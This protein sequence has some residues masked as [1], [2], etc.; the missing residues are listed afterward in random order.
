MLSA[1]KPSRGRIDSPR[2]NN[3]PAAP[4]ASQ[5]LILFARNACILRT[6]WTTATLPQRMEVD[7]ALMTTGSKSDPQFCLT[8]NIFSRE[9]IYPAFAKISGYKFV[10]MSLPLAPPPD[11]ATGTTAP[12]PDD[13]ETR[14]PFMTTLFA[15]ALNRRTDF[16]TSWKKA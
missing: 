8:I 16:Y 15:A 2:H 10:G 14:T 5:L 4:L 12:L 1:T 11:S 13:L 6:L 3:K 9:Q 7:E